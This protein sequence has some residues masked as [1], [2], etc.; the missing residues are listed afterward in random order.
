M[1]RAA[2]IEPASLAWKAKVLPLHNARAADALSISHTDGRQDNLR[3]KSGEKSGHLGWLAATTF[4]ILG[5]RVGSDVAGVIA[6]T[7]L[8]DIFEIEKGQCQYM[9]PRFQA[10]FWDEDLHKLRSAIGNFP[11]GTRLPFDFVSDFGEKNCQLPAPVN[12]YFPASEVVLSGTGIFSSVLL[13]CRSQ[14]SC[15]QRI[16]GR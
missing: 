5:Q 1:E 16:P 11:T 7:G 2:G 12:I 13:L 10:G 14:G 4:A 15:E 3:Q 8:P 6:A 9:I